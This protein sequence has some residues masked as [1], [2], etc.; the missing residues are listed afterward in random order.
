M[1]SKLPKVLH[2]ACGVPLVF[3]PIAEALRAGCMEVVVVLGHGRDLAEKVICDAFGDRV[4]FAVQVAQRGTGDAASAG[5]TAVS[6]SAEHVLICNGDTPLVT[7]ENFLALAKEPTTVLAVATA[8]LPE[9]F[10]YGRIMRGKDGNVNKI[11]E[12]KDLTSD[13]ER[14]IQEVNSGIYWVARARLADALA[15]LTPQN[16][17]HEY[18]LTDI[19]QSTA[20]SGTSVAGVVLPADAMRGVNDRD[21]LAEVEEVLSARI[22]KNHR[23]RGVTVRAGAA[24]DHSVTIGEDA[25][26]DANAVLRGKTTIGAG[27][28]IGVGAVLTDVTVE[29]GAILLPYTVASQSRMWARFR[30]CGQTP[31]SAIARMLATSSKRKRPN[32]VRAQKPTTFLTLATA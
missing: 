28:Q 9:P 27:A 5:M 24:I 23:K 6:A 13:S 14:A 1:K 2:A 20:T 21:Q 10:G 11:V 3:Y 4:K 19:V 29:E 7:A 17:Q 30:T 32:L 8:I 25:L 31:S 26:I 15:Q 22:V 12:Q 16:A 18:Y